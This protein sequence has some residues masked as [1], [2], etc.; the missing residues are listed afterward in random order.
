MQHHAADFLHYGTCGRL[1]CVI[2]WVSCPVFSAAISVA[3]TR[4]SWSSEIFDD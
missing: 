2:D 3:C 4:Q 1:T